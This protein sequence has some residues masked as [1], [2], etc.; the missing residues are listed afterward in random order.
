MVLLTV[1]QIGIHMKKIFGC[2][3][4]TAL[5]VAMISCGGDGGP[6]VFSQ[7]T[8]SVQNFQRFFSL[9]MANSGLGFINFGGGG[10][11][12]TTGA[13][14]TGG[15][16]VHRLKCGH[17]PA[18]AWTDAKNILRRPA[19]LTRAACGAAYGSRFFAGG[20]SREYTGRAKNAFSS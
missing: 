12:G 5:A 16:A 20:S 10:G 19:T 3:L 6:K 15:G 18:A 14:T 13:S 4:G 7:T 17:R 9:S 1:T 8:R 2:I 11:G